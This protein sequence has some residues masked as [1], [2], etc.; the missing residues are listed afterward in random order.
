MSEREFHQ[1]PDKT[2]GGKQFEDVIVPRLDLYR[3]RGIASIRRYGVHANVLMRYKDGTVKAQLIPSLPD[4]EGVFGRHAT[5]LVF[6]AKVCS[7]P[8]FDLSPY[9]P[10]TNSKKS[11]QLTHMYERADYG[12]PCFFLIHWNRRELVTKTVP[13]R[14]YAFPVHRNHPFWEAF[15]CGIEKR[16]NQSHCETHAAFVTWSTYGKETTPRPDIIDAVDQVQVRIN[17]V[18]MG[19]A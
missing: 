18:R 11:R 1:P 10:G 17:D 2:L 15:D 19:V 12:C 7:K 9:L 14:T 6:D 16:L 4:F 5:Q 8:S 13:P 3:K